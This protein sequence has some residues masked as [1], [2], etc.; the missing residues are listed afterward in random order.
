MK[1]R[2]QATTF[3][4]LGIFIVALVVLIVYLR[5]QYFFP[6]T[7]EN[8]KDKL[9][10]IE[11]HVKDCIKNIGDE[12]IRRIGLQGGYL[13]TPSGTYRLDKDITV[14]Y[15]CYNIPNKVQ[16]SNRMLTLENMESQLNNAIRD[17][18]KTCVNVKRF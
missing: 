18:L 9:V 13:S 4:I 2:G 8:L 17:S 11:S 15:L 3:V 7:P 6:A 14:S 5:N 16:C 1:K 10:A 12:P